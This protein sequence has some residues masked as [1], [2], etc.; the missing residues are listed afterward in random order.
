MSITIPATVVEIGKSAFE[1][2]SNLKSVI[3]FGRCTLLKSINIPKSV[4]VIDS[5]A[6]LNVVS[7]KKVVF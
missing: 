4:T 1:R 2:A 7:L 5:W 3:L 6:F